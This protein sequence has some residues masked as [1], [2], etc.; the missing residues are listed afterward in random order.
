MD[1]RSLRIAFFGDSLT[2]GIVGVSYFDLLRNKLP[3]HQLINHGKG[4][5]TVRSLYRRLRQMELEIP[6]ELGFLWIGVNDVFVKTS[7]TFPV[8]KRLRNQPW[9]KNK[10]EFRE[11]YI[12]LLELLRHA[13]THVYTVPPLFIGEDLGNP[14][15]RELDSLS[16][17]IRE[18]SSSFPGVE[19]IDLRTVIIP[20]LPKRTMG[21]YVPKSFVRII[22]DS[23]FVKT[24]E[25]MENKAAERGLVLTLDGIHLSRRGAVMVA[26]F[27]RRKIEEFS[28]RPPAA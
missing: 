2:E 16:Q 5:D 15:N 13:M 4:G 9:S 22:L 6:C 3:Y 21:L 11:D 28:N 26:E 8:I 25:E 19:F 27:F 17:I 20:H 14:W 24:P 18:V 12:K 1:R 7:W 23:L 10:E